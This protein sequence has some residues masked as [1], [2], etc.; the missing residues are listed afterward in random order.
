[1]NLVKVCAQSEVAARKET[2]STPLL[3]ADEGKRLGKVKRVQQVQ[4]PLNHHQVESQPTGRTCLLTSTAGD[5]VTGGSGSGTDL[6]DPD[7][8]SRQGS[9]RFGRPAH[10][11]L[12][13]VIFGVR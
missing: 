5:C 6:S 1:M 4:I 7:I 11:V 3:L 2:P 8:V 12:A 10:D 13:S 9:T